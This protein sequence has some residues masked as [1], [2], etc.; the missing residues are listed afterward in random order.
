MTGCDSM[1]AT[2]RVSAGCSGMSATGLGAAAGARKTAPVLEAMYM[3]AVVTGSGAVAEVCM[4]APMLQ[5]MS[6]EAAERAAEA[7][8][9]ALCR[10][11]MPG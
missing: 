6:M 8:A 2:V 3:E 1:T 4:T 11:P 10:R 5:E 7:E 9:A